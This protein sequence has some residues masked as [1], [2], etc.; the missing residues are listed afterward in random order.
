MPEEPG[1]PFSGSA[2][3]AASRVRSQALVAASQRWHVDYAG[4]N[5][6]NLRSMLNPDLC[7]DVARAPSQPDAGSVIVWG[8]QDSTNQRWLL[9][10]SDA[11]TGL[12]PQPIDLSQNYQL[13]TSLEGLKA[14]GIADA[15]NRGTG[16]FTPIISYYRTGGSNQGLNL[17]WYASDQVRLR[18]TGSQRCIDIKNSDTA[19]AGSPLVLWDRTDQLS[20]QWRAEEL[21]NGR[22]REPAVPADFVRP[23]PPEPDR[24]HD[25]L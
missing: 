2:R 9:T 22:G 11:T 24:E 12:E 3:P 8:C 18:G 7:M 23:T 15:F 1:C 16:N 25:E 5:E 20:Q 4:D 13:S 14:D 10:P 21:D 19:S 6:V 17:D